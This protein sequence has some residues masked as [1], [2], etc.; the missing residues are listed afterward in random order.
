MPFSSSL[1]NHAASL[2]RHE[3]KKAFP[4]SNNIEGALTYA[5][6]SLIIASDGN[7]SLHDDY[8]LS[9]AVESIY[10]KIYM[11]ENLGIHSSVNELR[12]NM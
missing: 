11:V 12:S 6:N 8:Q 1:L 7:Q 5:K 4:E 2:A 9:I 3:L 10:A